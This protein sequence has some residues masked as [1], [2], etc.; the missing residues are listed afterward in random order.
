MVY[1]GHAFL[2]G[3]RRVRF[4]PEGG[5][6]GA[7]GRVHVSVPFREDMRWWMANL[8]LLN[9]DLRTRIVSMHVP[10]RVEDIFLDASRRS[11]GIGIFVQ[12]ALAGL[13]G[14]EVNARY[15]AGGTHVS[16]SLIHI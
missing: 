8:C 1:G 7:S 3:V 11:G 5:V 4:R 15:P 2:H 6:R 13:K 9:G 10:D 12:G 16:L 14:L